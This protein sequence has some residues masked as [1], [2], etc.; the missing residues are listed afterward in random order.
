MGIERDEFYI[1][2][3]VLLDVDFTQAGAPHA[4]GSTTLVIKQ[5]DGTNVSPAVTI[6]PTSHAHAQFDTAQT[7]WHEWRWASTGTL[8][9]AMQGRFRVLPLNV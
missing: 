2:E 4:A 9:G 5:P 3:R 8:V 7:G 6:S 1:G